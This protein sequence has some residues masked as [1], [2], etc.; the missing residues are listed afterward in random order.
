MLQLHSTQLTELETRYGFMTAFTFCLALASA[1]YLEACGRW[2]V[3]L[4][5]LFTCNL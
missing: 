1:T 5:L 4:D 3:T 2:H